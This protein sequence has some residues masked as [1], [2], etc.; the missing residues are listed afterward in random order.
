VV[1]AQHGLGRHL[2]A[3]D[4]ADYVIYNKMTFFFGVTGSSLAL[5]FLRL[6][7]AFNLLRLCTLKWYQW[8][9]R[10]VIG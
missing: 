1:Q 5:G 10:A 2:V 9:L 8:A 4:P 7:I 6:S 3:I